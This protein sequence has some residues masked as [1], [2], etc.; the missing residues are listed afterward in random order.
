MV[1]GLRGKFGVLILILFISYILRTNKSDK[2]QP[3]TN[4]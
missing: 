1:K 2:R 4:S 3:E